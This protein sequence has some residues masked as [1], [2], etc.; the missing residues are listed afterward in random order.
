MA[1][2]ETA[3][4]NLGRNEKT[5]LRLPKDNQREGTTG[6]GYQVVVGTEG[7]EKAQLPAP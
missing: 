2:E 3:V 5:A 7:D 1:G 4:A 6:I